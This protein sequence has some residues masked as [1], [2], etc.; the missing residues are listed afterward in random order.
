MTE[1]Y[2]GW[3]ITARMQTSS[4]SMSL[5]TWAVTSHGLRAEPNSGIRAAS[6]AATSALGCGRGTPDTSA[7]SAAM[8]AA[9]P[10]VAI[11]TVP[12]ATGGPTLAKKAVRSRRSS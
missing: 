5:M 9:P 8:I 3:L 11:T 12:S 10:D 2:S 6:V 1:L 4:D 7:A